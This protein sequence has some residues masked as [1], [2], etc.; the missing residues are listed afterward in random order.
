MALLALVLAASSVPIPK[1]GYDG[2]WIRPEKGTPTVYLELFGDLV[3]PD[4]KAS[5]PTMKAV[6]KHYGDRIAFGF[7]RFPLPYHHN[8]FYAWQAGGV[9]AAAAP[10]AIWKWVD[11]FFGPEVRLPAPHC[12]LA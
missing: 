2:Y 10:D 5:W 3:C 8:A 4:T 7:H 11:A 6:T 1:G 12:T 9:V